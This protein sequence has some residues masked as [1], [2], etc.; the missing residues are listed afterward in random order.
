MVP[1]R[2]VSAGVPVVGWKGVGMGAGRS[3]ERMEANAAAL[4]ALVDAGSPSVIRD[5]VVASQVCARRKNCP[6]VG[7]RS[8]KLVVTGVVAKYRVGLTALIVKCDC[9]FPEYTVEANNFKTF[10]TTRCNICAKKAAGRKRYWK[11]TGAMP[12]DKHRSRLLNRLSAAINRC[13]QPKDAGFRNY[14]LRG[15]TV[16]E[17]W[18][19][20]RAAFLRYVRSIPGWDVP[21]YE[22]DRIDVNRGYE[23]GN[24]RFVS[25]KENMLNKRR[26]QDLEARIAELEARLRH[27]ELRA[28]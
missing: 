23:P 4:R 16:A 27:P 25:R 28:A 24:I 26:I 2:E 20:D 1:D 21:E 8:G 10:K 6:S 19:E 13:H 7:D 17:E 12:E 11:Y 14:G 5:P 15:I 18:R 3:V 22:L 9:G